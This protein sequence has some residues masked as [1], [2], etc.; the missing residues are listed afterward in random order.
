M[1]S[2]PHDRG[3]PVLRSPYHNHEA[4]S[5]KVHFYI[6]ETKMSDR[7]PTPTQEQLIKEIVSLRREVAHLK[8]IKVAFDAQHEL[9]RSLVTMLQT[10]NGTLMLRGLLQQTLSI[11]RRLTQAEDGSLFLLDES[12]VVTESILAR[13][14]TIR[15]QKQRLIGEVLN[16]GLAGWVV[17]NRQVG[18]ITDT[19]DDERWLTLHNQ[20]YQVRSALCVPILKGKQLLGVL[21][22]MHSQPGHFTPN[23]ARLMQMTAQQMAVI[24]ENA[25]LYTK[26]RQ[27]DQEANHKD[28]HLSE[29]DAPSEDEL[30]KLGIYIMFGDGNFLYVNHTFAGIFGYTFG[31]LIS[32][33]S[34]LNLVAT[35][36]RDFVAKAIN[37]CLQ[38]QSQ[39]LLCRFKG[40]RKDS[41]QINVKIYG[42]RTKLYGK[43]V[44]IG[45]LCEA[46]S[47]LA[48]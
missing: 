39:R 30:T 19:I 44:I 36:H 29:E 43:F 6:T 4:L 20:P 2:D 35:N 26:F 5:A 15:S 34:V 14:A 1:T 38:G 18:L 24:I 31:E 41:R 17:R 32:L 45:A 12:G 27:A 7:S 13:G 3:T 42:T 25:E 46:E 48:R 23:S 33:E 40:Q 37:Q 28:V 22:L 10:S 21:T 16:K 9:L 8:S 47:A 11:A